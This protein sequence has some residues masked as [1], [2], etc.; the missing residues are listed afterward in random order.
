MDPGAECMF[1]QASGALS[2]LMRTKSPNENPVGS[3]T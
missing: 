1:G 2:R 3:I